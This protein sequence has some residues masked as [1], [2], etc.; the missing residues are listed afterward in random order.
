MAVALVLAAC[1]TESVPTE[2]ADAAP[3][4]PPRLGALPAA[5]LWGG[6]ISPYQVEGGEDRTDWRQWEARCEDCARAEDGP[7]FLTHYERDLASAAAYGH[8]A[9]RLGLSWSRLFP[10]A[11]AFSARTPDTAVLAQYRDMIATA[12]RMGLTVVLTLQHFTLPEWLHTLDS[13]TLRGWEDEDV[14][15][16][17]AELAAWAAAE[18]GSD[19]DYWI[20]INEPM[21]AVARGWLD[22]SM[23]PGKSGSSVLALRVAEN[24]MWAHARAYDAI[25]RADLADAD[26]DG[27]NARVSLAHHGRVFLPN[28]ESA[29]ATRAAD[30]LRYLFNDM[31]LQAVIFGNIDRNLDGDFDDAD[32]AADLEPLKGRLDLIGLTYG[33]IA[34]V[35]P[36]AEAERF[37]FIGRIRR[38]LGPADYQKLPGVVAV[39]E[40][41]RPIY[42]QGL[43]QVLDEL[44]RYDRPILVT[45][46]GVADRSE[47]LRPRFLLDHLYAINQAVEEGMD[48]RGYLYWSLIDGFEWDAG[49]CPRLGLF[50]VDFDSPDKPRTPG[51]GAEV[52]RRVI[53]ANRVPPEL[54]TEYPDYARAG[55]CVDS[56]V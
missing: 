31:F 27:S 49:Y 46:N 40:S 11:E 37:P 8:N 35:E 20:T 38:D 32:D 34:V 47:T 9:V 28:D 45:A 22:G 33:S 48:I 54:F 29:A 13:E 4:S 2:G 56:G 52:L 36:T 41:G 12:R 6:G 55:V 19:V 44:G 10:T 15:L 17:F 3:P 51:V 18:F 16:R 30:M 5:F 43:R 14:T 42:P 1:A 53:E 26:G 21:V 23:P 39:S 7:D 25:H 50:R 24:M